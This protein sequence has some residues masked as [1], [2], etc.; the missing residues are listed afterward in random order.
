MVERGQK[1]NI[2]A[3]Y[4]LDTAGINGTARMLGYVKS[5]TR[6]VMHVPLPL[7]FLAPQLVGLSVEIPGEYKYSGVEWRYPSSA[8]YY[9]G[10]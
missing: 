3:G 5:D 9:D 6:L 4:G 8:V 2:T 10:I 7:R 1:I